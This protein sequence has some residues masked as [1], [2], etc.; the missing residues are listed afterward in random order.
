MIAMDTRAWTLLEM[1]HFGLFLR[2]GAEIKRSRQ[3][4]KGCWPRPTSPTGRNGQARATY[5]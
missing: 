5:D 4:V 3:Y 1:R 2:V